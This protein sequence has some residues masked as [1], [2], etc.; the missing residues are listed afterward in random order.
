MMLRDERDAVA[1]AVA[2]P[3]ITT[4]AREAVAAVLAAIDSIDG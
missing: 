3:A 2:D 1:V 4:S